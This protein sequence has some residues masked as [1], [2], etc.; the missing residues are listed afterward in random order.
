MALKHE[1]L[2]EALGIVYDAISEEKLNWHLNGSFNLLAQ[3][4]DIAVHD[5]DIETDEAGLLIF[6]EKLKEYIEEDR[7]RNEIEAHSLLLDIDG[8]QIEILAHDNPDIAMVS[9]VKLIN[10]E[11]M[12]IPVISYENA[13]KF[14]RMVGMENKVKLIEEHIELL[15]SFEI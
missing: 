9:D 7:Y 12:E 1:D 15:K 4:M 10:V 2:Y 8:V 13:K 14:Y 5:L 6:R 3:G 11:E